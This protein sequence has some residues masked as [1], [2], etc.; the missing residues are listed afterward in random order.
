MV[1]NCTAERSFSKMKIIK[2]RLRTSMTHERLSNLAIMSIEND[3]LRQLD[4]N[5]V[6]DEFAS[7]KVRKVCIGTTVI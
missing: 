4:F 7:K 6:I 2:N 1:T 5:E 3:I